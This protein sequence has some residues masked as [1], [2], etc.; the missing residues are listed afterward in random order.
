MVLVNPS[1]FIAAPQLSEH[2]AFD[3]ETGP[4]GRRGR[5][6]CRDGERRGGH[7]RLFEIHAID[8]RD[9]VSFPLLHGNNEMW[10]RRNTVRVFRIL[11]DIWKKNK[12][13]SIL[14]PSRCS[15]SRRDFHF[16]NLY[17]FRLFSLNQREILKTRLLGTSNRKTDRV[18]SCALSP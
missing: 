13:G 14:I 10:K 8:F 18:A 2:Q 7:E 9:I 16:S 12:N 6:R 15:F 11:Y 5:V 4:G 17:P 3:P 1:P